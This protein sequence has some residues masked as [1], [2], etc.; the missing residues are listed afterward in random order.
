MLE[1]LNITPE[2]L[3]S[4]ALTKTFDSIGGH[5]KFP[6]ETLKQITPVLL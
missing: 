6:C 1:L 5:S 3:L 2:L 4:Q